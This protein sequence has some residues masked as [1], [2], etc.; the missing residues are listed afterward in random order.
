MFERLT[1]SSPVLRGRC[2]E[3]T[4]GVFLSDCAMPETNTPS[5]LSGRL[6]RKTGEESVRPAHH[7]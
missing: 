3:V 1:L 7:V 5:A 4:E 6:P 2:H